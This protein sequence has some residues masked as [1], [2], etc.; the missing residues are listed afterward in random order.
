MFDAAADRAST[1]VTSS[2]ESPTPLDGASRGQR[3]GGGVEHLVPAPYAAL[4]AAMERATPAQPIDMSKVARA[5]YSERDHWNAGALAR[6]DAI[7]YGGR[8]EES[9]HD[10]ARVFAIYGTEQ[11]HHYPAPQPSRN[12]NTG[13]G[14][15]YDYFR[16]PRPRRETPP[17]VR[18]SERLTLDDVAANLRAGVRS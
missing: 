7:R 16:A 15:I 9:E 12:E 6:Q 10:G 18:T 17:T 2:T 8:I 5:V 3:V 11:V 13:G 1:P 4:A 14:D